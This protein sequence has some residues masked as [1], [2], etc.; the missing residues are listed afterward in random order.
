MVLPS[1][2][3]HLIYDGIAGLAFQAF[4]DITGLE[5]VAERPSAAVPEKERPRI[6]ILGGGFAN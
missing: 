3:R 2:V 1:L 5:P 6:L 4:A